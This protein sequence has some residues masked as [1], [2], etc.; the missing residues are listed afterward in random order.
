MNKLENNL[1]YFGMGVMMGLIFT[2]V[3]Y[4]LYWPMGAGIMAAWAVLRKE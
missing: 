3:A 1:W 2:P 4:T